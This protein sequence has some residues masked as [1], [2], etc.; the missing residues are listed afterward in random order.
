MSIIHCQFSIKPMFTIHLNNLKF[1]SY[2]GIHEEER[3][4][5]SEYL[6]NAA[7][8][9]GGEEKIV[10]LHQTVNYV[11]I[12]RIIKEHMDEP[13]PLLETLAQSI[14]EQIKEMDNQLKSISV[15]IEKMNPPI[16]SFTGSV[17]VT[18]S[19]EL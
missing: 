16:P 18:Y 15:R 2:H 17:G 1:Y 7:V 4:V 5:G 9:F 11:S 6:V 19:V 8:V 13:T 14:V 12:F 3:I 10:S